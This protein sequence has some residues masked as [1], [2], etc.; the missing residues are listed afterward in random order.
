MK[1][2]PSKSATFAKPQNVNPKPPFLL[3]YLNPA[4]VQSWQAVFAD[5]PYVD[6]A[7]GNM[8]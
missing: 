1:V 6:A 4:I 8:P 5:C 3:L 2:S 7:Y